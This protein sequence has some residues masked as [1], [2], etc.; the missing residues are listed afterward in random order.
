MSPTEHAPTATVSPASPSSPEPVTAAG[1]LLGEGPVWDDA[2]HRL[3]WVDIWGGLLNAT[4]L[5]GETTATELGAP[6]SSV[7]LSTRGTYVVTAG[8]CVLELTGEGTRH[9]ADIPED[10]CMRAN[11]AAVDPAGRLWIGTMTMPH[12]PA[13]PGGLWRLDPG[14]D[15]PV[16]VL[17]DVR[18]ANGL[19]WSP[20]GDTLYFV[21]SLRRQ[22]D[23]YPF[24]PSDGSLGTKRPFLRIADQ[25]GMP[26][27]IA[28]DADGGI[29]VALADGG[30]VRRYDPS[31]TLEEHV[32]LPTRC[33][34]SCAFGG[35][36]LRDLFV[37]T[38]SRPI[39]PAERPQEVDRGAGALFRISTEV[40][41]LPTSWMEV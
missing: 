7:V 36:G 13:R 28:V 24:D 16:R 22:V 21:D 18:L 31:G 12:R 19:A 40:R 14:S 15:V 5:A 30:V 35:T 38:A 26:D 23:A 32:A 27:G 33:P 3:L 10:P 41:G 20:S 4:S 29:W 2:T 25:D 9:L 8:L 39:P 11:D 34:T 6:V 17:D 37:T 1:A